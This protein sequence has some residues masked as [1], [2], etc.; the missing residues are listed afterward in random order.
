MRTTFSKRTETVMSLAA[1][2]ARRM[3]HDFVGT[4]HLLLGLLAEPSGE[5]AGLLRGLG[6]EPAS[7][8]AEIEK[9]VHHGAV[10]LSIN[11]L[12]FTPRATAAIDLANHEATM[13]SQRLVEPGHLLL[14][15]L[16]QSDGVAGMA[17]QNLGLN[18]SKLT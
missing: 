4:E 18:R 12:P 1:E 10:A 16:F 5:I 6:A 7:V 15:L 17:L 11:T 9:L 3:K 2:H 14:G 13:L 8:E